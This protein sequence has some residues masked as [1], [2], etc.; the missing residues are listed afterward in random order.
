MTYC[1]R[2]NPRSFRRRVPYDQRPVRAGVR[3]RPNGLDERLCRLGSVDDDRVRPESLL[4]LQS[5]NGVM[6]VQRDVRSARRWNLE[7]PA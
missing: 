3:G 1:R 5:A 2:R 7:L 4:S 6:Q